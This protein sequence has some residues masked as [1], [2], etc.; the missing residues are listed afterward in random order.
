MQLKVRE[1]FTYFSPGAYF[2]YFT[3]FFF[4]HPL[5]LVFIGLLGVMMHTE[6]L[7][8]QALLARVSICLVIN[9]VDR[10]VL[11]LKLPPQDAYYKLVHTIEEVN[12]IIA[13]NTPATSG[14]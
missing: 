6:K 2:T 3:L 12:K 11:E 1:Y 4:N 14:G 9:K 8:K 7:I 10:L 5:P 13:A